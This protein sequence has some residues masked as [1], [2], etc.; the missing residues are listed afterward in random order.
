[1]GRRIYKRTQKNGRITEKTYC[2]GRRIFEL[3]LVKKGA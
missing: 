3:R 2:G 1:M